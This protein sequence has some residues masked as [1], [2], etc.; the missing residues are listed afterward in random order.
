[1][2][3]QNNSGSR[4]ESSFD[5]TD[6]VWHTQAT[7]KRPKKEVLKRSW[8]RWKIINQRI[9]FHV[10]SDKI[11]EARSREIEDSRNLFRMEEISGLV[12]V[13][14]VRLNLKGYTIHIA[15]R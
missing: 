3:R 15:F 6:N 5:D 1:M 8:T 11:I 4:A 12:P 9:V 10:D 7:E 13:L 2:R 14:R